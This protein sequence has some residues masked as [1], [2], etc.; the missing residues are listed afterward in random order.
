MKLC[1]CVHGQL[2]STTP[3]IGKHRSGIR[4]GT[5]TL[6]LV[7]FIHDWLRVAALPDCI[8]SQTLTCLIYCERAIMFSSSRHSSRVCTKRRYNIFCQSPQGCCCRCNLP[9]AAR[10]WCEWIM[11]SMWQLWASQKAHLKSKLLLLSSLLPTFREK[12][13]KVDSIYEQSLSGTFTLSNK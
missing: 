13:E 2:A 5:I 10:V 9:P 12:I 7:F 6:R 4:N 3:C 1:W 11:A 8:R